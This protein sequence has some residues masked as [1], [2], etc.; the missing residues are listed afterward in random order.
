MKNRHQIE[1][2]IQDIANL[3][4]ACTH[5]NELNGDDL[6]AIYERFLGAISAL[7]WVKSNHKDID[8]LIFHEEYRK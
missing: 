1:K 2:K 6:G 3:W 7:N 4:E 8:W 5:C